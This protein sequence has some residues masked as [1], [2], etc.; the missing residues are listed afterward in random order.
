MSEDDPRCPT[1]A[2]WSGPGQVRSLELEEQAGADREDWYHCL[3]R[4]ILHPVS[5]PRNSLQ[6]TKTTMKLLIINI[7]TTDIKLSN[8]K[9]RHLE[10]IKKIY[11][12]FDADGG[13]HNIF[14]III[15][16]SH[17]SFC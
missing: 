13:P 9:R 7:I 10:R 17:P 11:L 16:L 6:N 3:H 1:L 15:V 12:F 8:K 14:Y 4:I 2:Q 5:L